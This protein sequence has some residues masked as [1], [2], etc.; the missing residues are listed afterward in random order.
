M[1]AIA[2]VQQDG[3]RNGQS[4]HQGARLLGRISH[5]KRDEAGDGRCGEPGKLR[6]VEVEIA[7]PPTCIRVEGQ[8][9]DRWCGDGASSERD[10]GIGK[11]AR[12]ARPTG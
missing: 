7:A 4:S 3:G 11:R 6:D 9:R 1:F 8:R 2:Q 10:T 5:C 12:H